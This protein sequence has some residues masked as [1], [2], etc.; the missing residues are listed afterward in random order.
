MCDPT[1]INPMG[2]SRAVFDVSDFAAL[3]RPFD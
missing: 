1:A 2:K 3:F